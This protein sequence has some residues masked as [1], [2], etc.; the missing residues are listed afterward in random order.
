MAP[1]SLGVGRSSASF[2]VWREPRP[3][4]T[5]GCTLTVPGACCKVHACPWSAGSPCGWIKIEGLEYSRGWQ[6]GPVSESLGFL[7]FWCIL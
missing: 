3:G 6:G 5:T 1:S 4:P 7:G 2:R